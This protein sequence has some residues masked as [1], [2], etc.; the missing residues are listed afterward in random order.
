MIFIMLRHIGLYRPFGF[1]H[2]SF[3]LFYTSDPINYH[4]TLI[5]LYKPLL[6]EDF[7]HLLC[8]PIEITISA[9]K[10]RNYKDMHFKIYNYLSKINNDNIYEIDYNKIV[11]WP[12]VTL[13]DETLRNFDWDIILENVAKE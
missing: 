9:A 3:M 6:S 7:F 5:K 11:H 10:F 1:S 13:R 12:I 2:N 8:P 4:D